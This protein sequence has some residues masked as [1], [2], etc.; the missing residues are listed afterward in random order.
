[1]SGRK[2][3]TICV[4]VCGLTSSSYPGLS[5]Q[6]AGKSY[7]CNRFVRP[8]KDDLRLNHPSVLNHSEFGTNVINNTH[9]LYWGE[10]V[11]GLEDGQD[12]TFQVRE[13]TSLLPLPP[14]L[15]LLLS[16]SLLPSPS[17][18]L[19]LPPS[20]SLPSSLLLLSLSLSFAVHLASGQANAQDALLMFVVFEVGIGT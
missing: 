2:S 10:K 19:L 20:P 5:G 12:V 14:S 1:M 9:F 6:G 8:K 11:V 4:A 18:S 17:L 13:I 16:P 15:S 3:S 7:L